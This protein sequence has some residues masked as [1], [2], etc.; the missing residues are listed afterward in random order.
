MKLNAVSIVCGL[1]LSAAT[2][3][4][5]S[6]GTP[7]EVV[8]GTW[9]GDMAPKGATTRHPITL[10]L[11]FD[12]KS[13]VSG[14]LLGLEIPGEIKAGTF[15]VR[16]GALKLSIAKEG[17]S[18][19]GLTFEGTLAKGTAS[20]TVV[21]QGQTGDFKV[22]RSTSGSAPAAASQAG[23]SE[24]AAAMQK[25]FGELSGWVT[26]AADMVPPDK[27]SYQPTATV[28]TFG[29]LIAHI[30]DGQNY[31]CGRAAGEKIE[32]SDAVEKGGTDKA[33]LVAKLKQS[34]DACNAAYGGNGQ[35]GQLIGNIGHTSLH[36]GNIITY[37]RMMGLTPPS[38]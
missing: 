5:Q 24:T 34:T 21:G 27:Y 2:A 17:E 35:A 14:K 30:A 28:R 1:L 9:K 33:T 26:K 15:N 37:M 18:E 13:E 20:G 19:I 3:I 11:R 31:Y 32:W 22:A 12:G 36:Y 16:T 4:A 10:E 7:A 23:A 38:S 6:A 25:G 8:S 29:Q